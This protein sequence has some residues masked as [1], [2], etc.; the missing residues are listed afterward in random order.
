MRIFVLVIALLL[1]I[2]LV[3]LVKAR[4]NVPGTSEGA[5]TCVCASNQKNPDGSPTYNNPQTAANATS[6]QSCN[7]AVGGFCKVNTMDGI[8]MESLSPVSGRRCL[9]PLL[10]HRCKHLPRR[11]QHHLERLFLS[12]HLFNGSR[13]C[14]FLRVVG[15]SVHA[16]RSL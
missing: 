11:V 13:D 3:E 1:P 16:M 5:C 7:R 10:D 8:K 9:G 14:M 2:G 12:S 6:P 4:D 15:L